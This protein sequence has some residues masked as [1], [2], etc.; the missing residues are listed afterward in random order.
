MLIV[1]MSVSVDGFIADRDGG[2]G[3]SVP[4]DELFR[5]HLEQVRRLGGCLLGRKLYE[6]ML[7]WETDPSMRTDDLQ[8]EFADVWNAI[9]K[10]VFSRTLDSVVGNARLAEKPL[11]EEVADAL[12]A[13]DGDVEIGGADLAGQA[14]ERG[15]VDELSLF[16]HPVVLG[17]GIPLLPP[18]TEPIPVELVGTR[19]FAARV[20][21]ECYRLPGT[22]NE[23]SR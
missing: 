9:P 12:A 20:I 4:D 3:W 6:T 15:L 1:S 7:P 13:T 17:G 5:F 16:R 11:V 18:L 19:T 14:L 23:P 21:H 2:L 22:G 10:V 8:A